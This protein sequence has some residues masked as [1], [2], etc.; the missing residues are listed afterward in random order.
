M[1]ENFDA[2]TPSRDDDALSATTEYLRR[3]GAA[4][5]A[6]DSKLGMHLYLAAFEEAAVESD[7]PS[8][9]ALRGLKQA[10]AL[11]CQN[12]ERSLAEYIYEKMEPYLS[13]GEVMRCMAQLQS[14]AL[15]RL[16]EFGVSR[17]DL[18]EMTQMISQDLMGMGGAGM[19]IPLS[20]GPKIV[21]VE[22]I[23]EHP[24]PSRTI[25]KPEVIEVAGEMTPEVVQPESASMQAEAEV[26][27]PAQGEAEANA[28][29]IPA[30]CHVG[31]VV[32]P[33]VAQSESAQA[34]S[35]PANPAA[36]FSVPDDVSQALAASVEGLSNL[37]AQVAREDGIDLN[38]NPAPLNY[39]TLAG[40]DSTIR[41]MRDLGIGLQDDEEFAQL[42]QTL[43]ARHG[44]DR[45]PVPD[46]MLFRAP[47]REDANRFIAATIGELKRPALRMHME[48]N[49]HG[50]AVL[51][52]T[53]QADNAPKLNSMRNAFEG[54]GVLVLED[55]DLWV[56]PQLEQIEDGSHANM[57]AALS[58]GAREAINLIRSA[59]ENPEVYVLASASSNGTI[60]GYFL[61]LLEPLSLIDIDYPTPEERVDIWMDIAREHPS[62]RG[63][64]RADLVRLSQ[65][66]PRYDMYM[67][68]REAIEEAYKLGVIARKYYPV[69][70]DNI[71]DKLAAY[72]PLDSTEYHELE[73]AVIRDFRRDFDQFEAF[74]LGE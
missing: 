65:N 28:A 64:N 19:S 34:E 45:M 44:L 6:G 63:V 3:A 2:N 13:Q 30:A 51:C 15:D 66:M 14:L 11:A 73:E 1:L 52:V 55:L 20:G 72:Q 61:D 40:Y 54:G 49:L 53:A 21:K 70:R 22:H 57:A 23:I 29:D 50:A 16:E 25:K 48:E 31:E 8:E 39:D 18:E 59:V 38:E 71:F 42:V 56:A 60:D 10:W 37:F 41:V 27:V 24:L 17:Q 35:A 7:V 68:A 46:S 43:N 36:E 74:I 67:A 33:E 47:V 4:C 32:S 5:E 12:K 62:I 26:S 58:R 9:A 69:S